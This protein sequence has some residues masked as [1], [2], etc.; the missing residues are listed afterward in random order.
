MVEA[1]STARAIQMNHQDPNG[2]RQDDRFWEDGRY[3]PAWAK[4]LATLIVAV[5]LGAAIAIFVSR[6]AGGTTK[7]VRTETVRKTVAQ[8][9]AEPEPK[10]VAPAKHESPPVAPATKTSRKEAE[11]NAGGGGGGGGKFL[12]PNAEASFESMAASL[13]ASVGLAVEPLGSEEVREFGELRSSGHAWS[14]I[15]PAILATVLKE[16]GEHLGPEEEAWAQSAI[17]ASDNEAAASLFGT[18]ERRQGGLEGAS[19]AVSQT[20]QEG[21]STGTTVATA[22]PPAG[23]VSTYGQTEWP[24]GEAV[25]FYH[26]LGRCQVL[27]ASG[28]G[29]IVSLMEGV[30]PEQRWGLGEAGFPADYRVAMKGGWGPDTEA[31]GSYLVRQSGLIQDADGGVAVAMIAVD[32]SGSYPAGAADLT[33]MA[34]WLAGELQGLGPTFH[35][36][37]G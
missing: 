15:K 16:Q 12:G 20:I 33:Q 17:T 29:M 26:A 4:V 25:R 5:G 27:G 13:P 37:A 1:R 9:Q 7:A 31:G 34:Q 21:G 10:E 11:E 2:R 23:A 19:A 30:I 8:A 18:I 28:T 6:S 3:T 36:C 32:Q 35:S 14:S 24:V 22:P